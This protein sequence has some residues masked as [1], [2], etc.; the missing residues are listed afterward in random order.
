MS[1]SRCST[2]PSRSSSARFGAQEGPGPEV[3]PGRLRRREP[4]RDLVG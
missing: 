3:E 4:P 1:T 2:G